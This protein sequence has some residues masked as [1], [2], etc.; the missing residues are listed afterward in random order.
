ML[1]RRI[2]AVTVSATALIATGLA[3]TPANALSTTGNPIKLQDNLCL[4][5]PNG[6][7]VIGAQI[8]QWGCNSTPAQQ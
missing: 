1:K 3:A 2:A 5:I 7:A 6:N 4:D 8:Q